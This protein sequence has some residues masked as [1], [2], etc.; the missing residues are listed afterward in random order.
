M[1]NPRSETFQRGDPFVQAVM[2][3]QAGRLEE[4][5]AAY[6]RAVAWQPGNHAIHA[7]L[8]VALLE[9]GRH[10]DALASLDRAIALKGDDAIAHNNRGNVLRALKRSAEALESY[11]RALSL[12]P[13]MALLQVNCGNAL[14]DL[15]RPAEALEHFDRAIAIE[16]RNAMAHDGRGSALLDLSAGYQAALDCFERALSIEPKLGSAHYN[17]ANAKRKLGRLD[18][19]LADFD[20]ALKLIPHVYELHNNR[21]SLLSE[22]RRFSDAL[23]SYERAISINSKAFEPH[24]NRAILFMEV[25]RPEDALKGYTDSLTIEPTSAVAHLGQ[26]NA[27]SRL[28]RNEEAVV[29]AEKAIEYGATKGLGVRLFATMKLCDWARFED[30][31][32]FL[33][34]QVSYYDD[35]VLPFYL[36]PA[37]DDP[38]VQRTN[39]EQYIAKEYSSLERSRL[40]IR[41]RDRIRIGYVSSEFYNHAVMQLL[42]ETLEQHDRSRF[43]IFGFST[44]RRMD[45]AYRGRAEQAC[46]ELIGIEAKSETEAAE[47]IR[48]KSID[49]AVD[50]S[51]F[52]GLSRSGIFARGIAPIQ[53]N[54]LGYAGTLGAPFIDY[55]IGDR[56]VSDTQN[57]AGFTECVVRL[58]GTFMPSPG[59]GSLRPKPTMRSAHGLPDDAFV[60]A[61]LNSHHKITP[62]VF[63]V[64]MSILKRTDN[65]VLWL[66]CDNDTAR[67]NLAREAEKRGVLA[68][69]VLFTSQVAEDLHLGRFVMADLFLDTAPYNAHTTAVEAVH[70]GLPVLTCSGATFASRV[71]KSILAA[72]GLPELAVDSWGAYEEMA[73][74]LAHQPLLMKALRERLAKNLI[75]SP[76]LDVAAYTRHLERAYEM[77]IERHDEGLSPQDL[78]VPLISP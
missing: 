17:S 55:I 21:G 42:I 48:S 10:T 30:D 3:H 72:V 27:L 37:V 49:I 2:L 43:E 64:W 25:G 54:Y 77:M 47:I 70:C 35:C 1:K 23:T 41:R 13:R 9:L 32:A 45:D 73:V 60:F 53:V 20:S 7:N 69:R 76:L 78:D 6:D 46:T 57:R 51:G 75:T 19:A 66:R 5:S 65:S 39:A 16:P 28:G 34:S 63:D 33:T 50:L 24:I 11:E 14:L 36:L 8:G 26:A 56:I 15:K 4:A 38:A 61:S 74:E 52:T 58:P 59:R 18:D 40:P 44:A 71:A 68:S 12:S 67:A 22:L 29:S 31:C 62:A